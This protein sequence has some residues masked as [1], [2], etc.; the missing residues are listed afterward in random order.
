[1]L[2]AF[3]L[4]RLAPL[5]RYRTEMVQVSGGTERNDHVSFRVKVTDKNIAK[6]L[7][8]RVGCAIIRKQKSGKEKD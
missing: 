6:V 2:Y 4:L 7:H 3:R 1:M 5:S 8:L